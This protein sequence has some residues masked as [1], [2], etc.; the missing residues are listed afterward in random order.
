VEGILRELLEGQGIEFLS[1]TSRAK[2]L[3]SF[4][5]KQQRKKYDDPLRDMTDL[6]GV[7]VV[8][9]L[10]SDVARVDGLVRSAFLID[11]AH[12]VDKGGQLPVDRV[13]YRSVH[14]VCSLGPERTSLGEY[15]AFGDLRFE[16]QIRTALEHAWAQVEHG[17]KYK[18]GGVLPSELQRR[19]HVAAGALELLDGELDR[20]AAEV[21][22]YAQNVIEK[23]RE[24][25]LAIE[26]NTTSL[27]AYLQVRAGLLRNMQYIPVEHDASWNMLLDELRRFGVTT[28][29]EVDQLFTDEFIMLRDRYHYPDVRTNEIGITRDALMFADIE[30]FFETSF[31][32]RWS[33]LDR[34]TYDMLVERYGAAKVDSILSSNDVRVVSDAEWLDNLRQD[35]A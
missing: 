4:S 29:A 34:G 6:C 28:L 19:L 23:T 21:D 17:R 31:Q 33:E 11:P 35:E 18:F 7:R 20:I 13:G 3:E 30:K 27:R 14:L 24:G 32:H 22:A 8:T 25:D 1:I 12:S 2:T 16:L 9:Y 10:R 26:I 15:I 5:G